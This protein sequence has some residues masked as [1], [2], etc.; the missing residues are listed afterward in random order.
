M[1]TR[2]TA[3]TGLAALLSPI[4]AQGAPVEQ[5]K[6]TSGHDE[7]PVSRYAA[8]TPGNALL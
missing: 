5:F 1:I 8:I 3:L 6:V 4:T 7:L 2:R